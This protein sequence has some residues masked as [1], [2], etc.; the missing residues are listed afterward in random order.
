MIDSVNFPLFCVHA[1]EKWQFGGFRG[2]ARESGV[3]LVE[4]GFPHISV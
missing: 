2:D 3:E 4:G 1:C